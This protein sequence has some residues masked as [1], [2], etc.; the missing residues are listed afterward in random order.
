MILNIWPPELERRHFCCFKPQYLGSFVTRAMGKGPSIP[1]GQNIRV[2]QPSFFPSEAPPPLPSTPPHP[3]SAGLLAF[4]LS[5]RRF[6]PNMRETRGLK[7]HFR[8][9]TP[10][11][12]IT[13]P[14]GSQSRWPWKAPISRRSP[15]FSEGELFT[16]GG[17]GSHTNGA[18]AVGGDRHSPASGPRDCA[19]SG[20]AQWPPFG[21]NR[22]K[23][24]FVCKERAGREVP[25]F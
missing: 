17:R 20:R 15:A 21:T 23:S 3:A 16:P 13:R 7:C 14:L 19:A 5:G 12:P 24:V 22:R 6:P 18:S 25:G 11:T 2:R 8:N 1:P 10:R 4:C 9:A